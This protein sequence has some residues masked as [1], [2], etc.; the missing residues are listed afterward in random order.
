MTTRSSEAYD[1][2]HTIFEVDGEAQAPWHELVRA[3]LDSERDV[4][5]K[6]LLEIG[7]GRGGFACWLAARSA[8]PSRIVA[9]DIS[10]VAVTKGRAFAARQGLPN[11]AWEVGD[12]HELAHSTASFDTVIS[13]ETIE[14]VSDPRRAVAELARVL[15]PGGRLFL[16]TPNYLGVMGLYRLYVRLRGRRYTEMDQPINQLTMWPRTIAWIRRT[17]LQ[18]RRAD[19]VGHYFLFPRRRP[20]RLG[21]LDGFR[22]LTRWTALHSLIVAEKR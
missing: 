12:I 20:F 21:A 18:I 19:G 17:G 16:T 2:W 5:G 1:A 4:A 11:I 10:R 3:H 14:H 9:V 15:R 8:R 13:F 7:C 22:L 6:G